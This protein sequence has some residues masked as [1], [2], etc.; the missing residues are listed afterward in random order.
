MTFD[1]ADITEAEPQEYII[2]L[3]GKRFGRFDYYKTWLDCI[4]AIRHNRRETGAPIGNML[5]SEKRRADFLD[6]CT[7]DIEIIYLYMLR[8]CALRE[9]KADGGR[10]QENDESTADAILEMLNQQSTDRA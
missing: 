3:A 1:N 2:N 10:P 9:T 5:S 8:E 7:G 4:D 6:L